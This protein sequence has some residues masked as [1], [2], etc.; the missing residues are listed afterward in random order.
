MCYIAMLGA[1][2][3]FGVTRIR[4]PPCYPQSPFRA[5]GSRR[6]TPSAEAFASTSECIWCLPIQ[7]SRFMNCCVNNP[8]PNYYWEGAKI[9]YLQKYF[10]F[11]PEYAKKPPAKNADGFWT[12]NFINSWLNYL[13]MIDTQSYSIITT[14]LLMLLFVT[15]IRWFRLKSVYSA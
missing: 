5:G 15:G 8:S 6:I 1:T 3:H 10:L 2:K 7:F 12:K 9:K 11:F 14:G 4:Y 13:L